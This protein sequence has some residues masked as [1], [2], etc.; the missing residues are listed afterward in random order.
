MH[1]KT[2]ASAIAL[3]TAMAFSGSAMAQTMIGSQAVSEADQERVKVFCEDLQNTEN[4]AVG[5]TGAEDDLTETDDMSATDDTADAT[6]DAS[7]TADATDDD[8][9][10]AAVGSI[11]MDLITLENC[12]DAGFIQ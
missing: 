9:D 10:S 3:T 11:D 1:I 12:R 2:I 7:D 6:D 4:Q 5:A 8:T